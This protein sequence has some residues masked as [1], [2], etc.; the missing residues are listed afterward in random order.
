LLSKSVVAAFRKQLEVVMRK[1]IRR[2]RKQ[3]RKL[4]EDDPTTSPVPGSE[5]L[6]SW[7][8]EMEEWM[9]AGGGK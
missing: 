7:D 2:V 4:F 6:E 9:I 8:T 1:R 5:E 3:R